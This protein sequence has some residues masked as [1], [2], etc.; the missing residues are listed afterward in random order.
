MSAPAWLTA[1]PIAHRGLH[2]AGAG[3]IENTRSAFA[4]AVAH[5]FAIECDV[6]LSRD[7]EAMVHHDFTLDRLTTG[8]GRLDALTAAEI[9]ATPFRNT[10]DRIESLAGILAFVAGRVPM[11]IE[12]KSAF[13]GDLALTKRAIAAV[14]TAGGPCALKSF[15]PNIVAALR[16]LAPEIPRGIIAQR[17][18]DYAEWTGLDAPL[19]ER[20]GTLAHLPETAPDFLSYRVDDLPENID[21]LRKEASGLPLMTWTVRTPVQREIAGRLADQMVFEGFVP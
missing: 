1:S 16:M 11:V 18:Y 20:L 10:P 17:H 3:V 14:R 9:A 2:D 12:I 7:G 4:A 15:D 5:G 6:Q 8:S 19:R 13:T 21:F